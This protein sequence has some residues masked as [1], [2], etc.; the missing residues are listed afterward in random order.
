M[1]YLTKSQARNAAT[2]HGIHLA[3]AQL[4]KAARAP[5]T[6]TFDI[7]LSHSSEDAT[8]VAGIKLML[9]QESFSVYVDWIEDPQ[10]DRSKVTADTAEF[11]VNG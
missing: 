7:F 6:T 11:S 5:L 4:Q 8:V 10:M 3:E 9:E 2:A 1:A